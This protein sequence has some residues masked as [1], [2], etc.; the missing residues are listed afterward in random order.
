MPLKAKINKKI[1][2]NQTHLH[3]LFINKFHILYPNI[4]KQSNLYK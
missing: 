3:L 2:K 1:Y 4:I